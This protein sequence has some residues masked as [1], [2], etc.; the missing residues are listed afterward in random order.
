MCASQEERVAALEARLAELSNTVGEYDIQR[1][2]DQ[3]IIQHLRDNVESK[4]S[5]KLF[6]D[7][8]NTTHES[9]AYRKL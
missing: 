5:G 9:N 7:S 6:A 2:K 3:D 1:R 4:F 8:K